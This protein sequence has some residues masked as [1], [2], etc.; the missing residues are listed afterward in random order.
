MNEINSYNY[1]GYSH[2]KYLENDPIQYDIKVNE[3]VFKENQGTHFHDDV[4]LLFLVNGEAK[5]YVNNELNIIST[6]NLVMLMP[7]HVHAIKLISNSLT[8]YQGKVSLGLLLYS[9][10]SRLIEKHIS[11]SL[12]YGN[13][14]ARLTDNEKKKIQQNFEEI[15]EELNSD[16]LLSTMIGLNI[17]TK[18][19]LMFSRNIAASISADECYDHSITWK[20]MQ[21]MNMNFSNDIS[22]KS[23]ATEFS[24]SPNKINNYFYLLTGENLSENLH[25]TRIR[26]ACSMFQFDELSSSYIGK[27]VGYKNTSSF[28]RKFKEIKKMTPE[29]Y[30]KSH[31]P[32]D[33]MYRTLNTSWKILLYLFE[34]Y[35]ESLDVLSI[36]QALFLSPETIHTELLSNFDTSLPD[37]I[38]KIRLQYAQSFLQ[39]IDAPILKIAYMCGFSSI[40]TFNR[41]FKE[42]I[43][44]TPLEFRK[45]KAPKS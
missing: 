28:F 29:E 10:I 25:R 35:T 36:S 26:Y 3:V 40:R 31:I 44:C 6:G 30:R 5:L 18:I 1:L 42:L 33:G 22:A 39:V 34:H 8:V 24:M 11:Y 4:E 37:L 38:T 7:Y 45:A 27:Y 12:A 21:Y 20:L 41:C 19:I 9:S 32:E 14:V 2:A 15:I 13:V 43:G 17:I 16:T 23:M